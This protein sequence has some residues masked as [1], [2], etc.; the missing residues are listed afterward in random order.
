MHHMVLQVIH[1]LSSDT[2]AGNAESRSISDVLK[3]LQTKMLLVLD[4]V[5]DCIANISA[6]RQNSKLSFADVMKE[7]VDSSSNV[8]VLGDKPNQVSVALSSV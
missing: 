6:T 8:K 3:S 2:C 5:E 1:A 4:N 7:I